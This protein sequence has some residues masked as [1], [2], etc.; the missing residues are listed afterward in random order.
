MQKQKR[1][2]YT[3]AFKAKIV[4]EILREEKTVSQLSA[5]YEIHSSQLYK[6]RDQALAGLPGLFDEQSEK[7]LAEKEIA[8]EREREA[9]Y[10]EIGRL[11]TEKLWLEKKLE[12]SLRRDERQEL[13]DWEDNE[14][15]LSTQA[16]LLHLNRSSLYYQPRPP[17]AE[18]VALKHRID[19]IFTQCPFYG[20]RRIAEQ[21]HR[22]GRSVNKKTVAKYMQEM[23]LMAIFPGPNLSKRAQQAAIFPYLLRNLKAEVPDHIWGV[24]ITYIRL[25][26]GWM[27]LV[28]VL[29][30][31]SRYIV[32]WELDQSLRQD[33][34][35][36]AMH[37]A[38]KQ[39]TPQICNSDQGSHFTSTSY[40][41]LLKEHEVRISM[42]GKGR[43]LDNIFT[44]R[45]WR[46]I[47]YEEVYVKE[48]DSPRTARRELSRYLH[49][50]NEE[51]LHQALDYQTPAER[52]FSGKRS[53]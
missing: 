13:I 36:L 30:W 4:K 31:Y 20:Y 17:S 12:Q 33:F 37:N 9:L 14:L 25:R 41:N 3:A 35:L 43:A 22:E 38:L 5:E 29:D 24:D 46:T 34:V 50:Y 1:K 27:F 39:A 53:T 28:A 10:A 23:G 15:P 16:R 21:L 49:F 8:W 32:S 47:K 18:E 6:W 51:R 26:A 19:E 48:Y 44:E 52:Y 42:D 40:I 7:A 2:Q 45:L 11:T